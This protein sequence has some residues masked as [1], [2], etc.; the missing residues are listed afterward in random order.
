M[1]GRLDAPS[2]PA[3]RVYRPHVKQGTGKLKGWDIVTL[4][5]NRPGEV[6]TYLR[7]RLPPKGERKATLPWRRVRFA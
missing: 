4:P 3:R 7:E 6:T 5:G 2:T 1:R